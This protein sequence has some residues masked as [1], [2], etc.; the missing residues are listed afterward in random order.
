[1]NNQGRKKLINTLQAQ[2]GEKEERMR[3]NFLFVRWRG[4]LSVPGPSPHSQNENKRKV[5][6]RR[7]LAAW[8]WENGGDDP[9]RPA[10][11]GGQDRKAEDGVWKERRRWRG[12][13]RK[14][15]KQKRRQRKKAG[16]GKHNPSPLLCF[17]SQKNTFPSSMFISSLSRS[18]HPPF[19]F[20]LECFLYSSLFDR[21]VRCFFQKSH[22]LF[23]RLPPLCFQGDVCSSLQCHLSQYIVRVWREV[24]LL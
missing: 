10:W 16:G 22:F 17:G 21:F 12:R 18:L 8:R 9:I 1:M 15:W 4:C 14:R 23:S 3:W 20:Y 7:E 6:H 13:P 2:I 11:T 24:C 5:E 19:C